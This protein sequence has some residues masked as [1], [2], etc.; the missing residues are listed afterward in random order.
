MR[1]AVRSCCQEDGV[2]SPEDD[3]DTHRRCAPRLPLCFSTDPQTHVKVNYTAPV[4]FLP[5]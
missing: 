5:S 4:I 3:G 1:L 2:W